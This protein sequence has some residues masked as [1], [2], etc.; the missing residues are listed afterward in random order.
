MPQ[1][2]GG[3]SYGAGASGELSQGN[4]VANGRL[5]THPACAG[6]PPT[7]AQAQ[8]GHLTSPR[9]QVPFFVTRQT[10]QIAL[11]S[12]AVVHLVWQTLV[13]CLTLPD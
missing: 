4:Q 7:Q 6:R 11:A 2:D 13:A 1:P 12:Q 3:I 10:L 5:F 8:N 9:G